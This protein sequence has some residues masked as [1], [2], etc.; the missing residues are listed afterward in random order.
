MRDYADVPTRDRHNGA[1][2]KAVLMS[3]IADSLTEDREFNEFV[4]RKVAKAGNAAD[5]QVMEWAKFCES[6]PYRRESGEVYRAWRECVGLETGTPA[7]GD[8]DDLTILVVAGLR[9][10]GMQ[11]MVEILKDEEGWG[12]HVRARVGL[13][14]HRPTYWAVVDPVWRSEREWAM[15]EKPLDQSQLV[16]QSQKQ[17]QGQG[18]S[19]VVVP[20]SGSWTQSSWTTTLLTLAA[21]VGIGIWWKRR[22]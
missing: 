11:S 19:F 10:L 5:E 17:L 14:P 15:A 13:P 16:Q 22:S 18:Q 6:L 12:F 21:G 9:S 8:C 20:S 1:L 2:D 3:E 4:M 7:G